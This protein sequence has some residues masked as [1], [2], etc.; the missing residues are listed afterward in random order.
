MKIGAEVKV[1]VERDVDFGV[2]FF[3]ARQKDGGATSIVVRAS[4]KISRD[5]SGSDGI[6]NCR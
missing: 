4:H 5:V 1:K 6:G 3:G 2:C